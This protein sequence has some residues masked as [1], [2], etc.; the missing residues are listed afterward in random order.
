MIREVISGLKAKWAKR[1][2]LVGMQQDV[3]PVEANYDAVFALIRQRSSEYVSAW[4]EIVPAD[5]LIGRR[6]FGHGDVS[7]FAMDLAKA[8]SLSDEIT[9]AEWEQ[10]VTFDDLARLIVKHLQRRAAAARTR[11]GT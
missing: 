8:V 4:E 7:Y 1:T 6:R 11:S 3:S 9:D 10:V 2:L 5:E